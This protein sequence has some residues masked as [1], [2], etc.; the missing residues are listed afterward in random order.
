MTTKLPSGFENIALTVAT[1]ATCADF[2]FK[3]IPFE[4]IEEFFEWVGTP[5]GLGSIA[6]TL[7][8]TMEK[9]GIITA[10]EAEDMRQ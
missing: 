9:N 10:E 6:E 7:V 2:G 8:V 4:C 5:E 3:G 1:T